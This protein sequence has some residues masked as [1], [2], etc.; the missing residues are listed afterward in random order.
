MTEMPPRGRT[1]DAAA[2]VM[3]A[4]LED[5]STFADRAYVALRDVIVVR[6]TAPMAPGD[7]LPLTMPSDAPPPRPE[8]R[9][10]QPDG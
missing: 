3:L 9:P 2:R 10:A 1:P 7:P 5:T 6:G 8:T 4:P